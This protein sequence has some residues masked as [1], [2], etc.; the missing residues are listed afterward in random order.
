MSRVKRSKE[1][2]P[3]IHGNEIAHYLNDRAQFCVV[4]EDGTTVYQTVDDREWRVRARIKQGVEL[5]KW[6]KAKMAKLAKME[7][8]RLEI[9]ELPSMDQVR[10]W[11]TDSVCETTSGDEIEPDGYGPD[12]A[13]S[14][15]V[16]LC[17]I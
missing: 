12:G 9:V 3:T 13:P 5:D 16:A 6:R 8:W 2:L 14:W 7:A 10:E 15:L 1:L 17:L 4:F 11:A